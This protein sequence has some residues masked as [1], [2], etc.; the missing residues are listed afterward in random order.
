VAKVTINGEVFQFDRARKPMAEMMALEKA[1]GI[2]YGQWEHD[3]KAG[4]ARALAGFC[5]LVWRRDG[6]DVPF[7]DIES[8]AVSIDLNEFD[9][10]EDEPE[11][12]AADPTPRVPG[13]GPSSTG[14]ASGSSPSGEK[15]A[16][17]HGKSST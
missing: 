8:G 1:L 5:W 3:L 9:I 4:S 6:R 17:A 16:S 10:E 13:S 15:P 12:A 11:D 7:S 2:P 14:P